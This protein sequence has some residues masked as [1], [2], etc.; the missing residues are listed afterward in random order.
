VPIIAV[1]P[2]IVIWLDY[3]F[4]SVVMVAFII[5]LFPIIT[6]ATAGLTAIDRNLFELFELSGASRWQLLWKLRFPSS[7]P[8]LIVGAKTSAGLA[9]VGAIVGEIFAGAAMEH[10][11]LGN[12]INQANNKLNIDFMF[13]A[14]FT[15]T[16]LGIVIFATLSL[17][18]A[19]V[20]ARWQGEKRSDRGM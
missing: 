3:G 12:L 9:V 17:A 13:A 5:S 16:C 14:V 19:W 4:R 20:M 1:A 8:H 2:L 15:S 10:D 7:V 18:G 6:N 11:G